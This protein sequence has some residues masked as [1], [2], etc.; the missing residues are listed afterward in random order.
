MQVKAGYGEPLSDSQTFTVY[1]LGSVGVGF[2]S[3]I[4]TVILAGL[5]L[6][7]VGRAKD[8]YQIAGENYKLRLLFLDPET[9]TY[10]LSKFQ[11]YLWTLAALFTYSYLYISIVFVQHGGWPDI[12]GTLPGIAGIGAGT[13]IGSQLVTDTKGSKGAGE[14]KPGFAD[15]VTSGGVVAADRLQM[16]LWTIFGVGAFCVGV[17]QKAPGTIN[18]IEPVPSGMMYMMGLSATGY[19]GGKMAR[20]PGPVI[21]ELTVT[22]G[23]SDAG[24]A[25][26]AAVAVDLPDLT[27]ISV[28][29]AANLNT[30]PKVANA[31]AQKAI[32]AFASAIKA[33]GAVHTTSDIATLL[34]GMAGFRQTCEKAAEDTAKDFSAEPP[35]AT[36][37]EASA[38]QEAAAFLQDF[39]GDVTQA[40]SAAAIPAMDSLASSSAVARSIELRGSN[41]SPDCTFEVGHADLP[42]RMLINQDGQNAPDVVARQDGT[43]FAAVLRFTIDPARLDSTDLAQY[44][45]WFGADAT[46]VATLT[47]PDG[48]KAD[49][50]FSIPPVSKPPQKAT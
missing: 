8:T 7:L 13:A 29:A 2:Y 33:A 39:T 28:V 4:V 16:F 27:Q 40:I 31:N 21:T 48:Q 45:A 23:Q 43:D 26:V 30:L 12:P 37:A 3:L 22:P 25:R 36:A 35:A 32:D 11:F 9:D 18:G 14:E 17:L 47:N 10:S 38:A 46:W 20:K 42:F 6:Y 49:Q 24:I 44:Q 34:S 15:F 1:W 5:A 19:L 41:L 50:T